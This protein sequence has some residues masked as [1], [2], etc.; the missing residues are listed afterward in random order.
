MFMKFPSIK[1]GVFFAFLVA[2]TGGLSPVAAA[3]SPSSEA[4]GPVTILQNQRYGLCALATAFVFDGVAYAKCDIK[5]GESISF[6]LSYPTVTLPGQPAVVIDS[7][8]DVASV[9]KTG[10]KDN[11]YMVS[12]FSLPTSNV[13]VYV[14]P[15][16]SAGSYAQC[17]GG[18]C[19]RSTSGT[20]FPGLGSVARGEIVCSCPVVT[21]GPTAQLS[22]FQ[23]GPLPCLNG[24]QYKALCNAP[25]RNGSTLYIGAPAP[26]LK[27]LT[28]LLNGNTG[29]ITMC[30]APAN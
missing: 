17:D 2:T 12:T 26:T 18:I 13:G 7:G 29:A 16:G 10:N 24:A 15:A 9:N 25:V 1:Q 23:A 14:C 8:G 11:S 4:F 20:T 27:H 28:S 22:Y 30:P 3:E 19:F 5:Y 21:P 6:T